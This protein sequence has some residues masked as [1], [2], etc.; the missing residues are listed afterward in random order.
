MW[1]TCVAASG[2]GLYEARTLPTVAPSGSGNATATALLQ[3]FGCDGERSNGNGSLMRIAPL[4]LTDATDDEVRAVS[5]ITHAHPISTESCV[6]F[7]RALRDVLEG[8]GL[9]EAIGRNIPG[10]ERFAFLEG[11]RGLPRDEIRSTGYVLD[12]L[13]AALWCACNTDSYEECVTEAVNLGG[14]SRHHRLRRWRAGSRPLRLRFH[15]PAM[16]EPAPRERGYRAV[17]ILMAG[18]A[19]IIR[20]S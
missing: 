20:G 18:E 13:G 16:A 11:I 10:D 1:T 19:T 3:G 7:V 14:D 17:P 5:A 2:L 4:A 15:S 8:E 6:F 12:T 9:E